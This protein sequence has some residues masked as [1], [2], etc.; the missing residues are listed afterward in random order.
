M[1]RYFGEM[2]GVLERHGGIVEKY[3]GDAVM[4]VF[5]LPRAHEDDALRAVRAAFEMGTALSTLNSVFEQSW[6][7]TLA[8]RT[9]VNTGEVVVGDASSGQRLATGDAVN[10]AARLEQAAP[11]GE[12]LIGGT[13]HHLVKDA[14]KVQAVE[15]LVLKGKSQPMAA[16]RV[17]EVSQG[18]I[19][20]ARHLDAPIVGR[21]EEVSTLLKGFEQSLA[22]QSCHLVTVLG[23]AGVGKSRLVAEIVDRLHGRARVLRGRCLSYGEGITFWPLAEL[24]KGAAGIVDDDPI[25]TARAKLASMLSQADETD[26]FSEHLAAAIGLSSTAFPIEETFWA[27]RKALEALATRQ[28]LVILFE[29]IHWA[30]PT[31]LDLIEYVVE[32]TK[33]S[34]MLIICPARLELLEQRPVWMQSKTNAT[35][36]SLEPLSTNE[37]DQLIDNL[38]GASGLQAGARSRL[39]AAAQGNPLFLEQIVSMWTEDGTLFREDGR[40]AFSAN[41]AATAIPP[42][43]SALLSARLDRLRQEDRLTIA[44][45]SVV[46]Q[47]F[48]RGAV[49]ELSPPTVASQVPACLASLAART[50]I[51]TE[52]STFA[53]EETFAFR[54][55]LIRDSAYET[56]LKRTR[57]ELHERFEAWLERA[58]G[59]RIDEYEEL[60]GYHLEQACLYREMLGPIDENGVRLRK[61]AAQRLASAGRRA[62]AGSDMTA[63]ANL[64]SRASALLA[65]ADIDRANLLLDLAEVLSAGGEYRR[66]SEIVAQVRQDI[67]NSPGN[68]QLDGK[69][70]LAH[71]WSKLQM[72]SKGF[73][74][75]AAQAELKQLIEAADRSGDHV[76][77]GQSQEMMAYLHACQGHFR[78]AQE[79]WEAVATIV[80][81]GTDIVGHVDAA[82]VYFWGPTAVCDVIPLCEELIQSPIRGKQANGM[83]LLGGLRVMQG[84]FSKAEELVARAK[85]IYEDLG[86]AVGATLGPAEMARFVDLPRSPQ[87]AEERLRVAYSFLEQMGE[88]GQLSTVA[89]DLAHV[90]YAQGRYAETLELSRISNDLAAEDDAMSQTLW[91]GACAK[92]S[93]RLGEINRAMVL[94][95]E[96]VKI[97]EQT[98]MLNQR[99]DTLMDLAEVLGLS[100]RSADATTVIRRAL[101]VYKQK[102]NIVSATR[103]RKL[104]KTADVPRSLGD[105]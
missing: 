19:G 36:I 4:A 45:A 35:T 103:A 71:L 48:Y 100:N 77:V 46:G 22:N 83:R 60:L 30:E 97:S 29:D 79:A 80:E 12:I 78:A 56:M 89:G 98:D 32:Y 57:A 38:L 24:M 52:A 16:L 27:T 64:L 44:V 33:G 13:T 104:L 101:Q 87:K 65:I 61:R 96:A 49:Q 8:N 9:G 92:A 54:H 58:A 66:A 42:T 105:N 26:P 39:T 67:K 73:S 50:F 99:G 25:A 86:M 72:Q 53:D 63:A 21:A 85:A 81:A 17:V 10:V 28:P 3:I 95:R 31:F 68:H 40:W 59:E 18:I 6:G 11:V 14:V 62:R 43:I 55:A 41:V 91:R 76:L 102:G 88:K 23:E 82:D 74:S 94:A 34:S 84:D 90:V 70:A 51:R 5:G 15:P 7:V 69:V 75:N 37:S 47:V 1:D 20:V 2:R 93:A